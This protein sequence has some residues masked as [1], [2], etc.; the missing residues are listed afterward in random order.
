MPRGALLTFA[1]LPSDLASMWLLC[2]GSAA[3]STAQ[4]RPHKTMTPRMARVVPAGVAAVDAGAVYLVSIP[5]RPLR[6]HFRVIGLAKILG[7]IGEF[8]GV[9]MVFSHRR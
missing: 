6:V 8:S 2:S 9:G 5:G 4:A 1:T 3:L 7:F